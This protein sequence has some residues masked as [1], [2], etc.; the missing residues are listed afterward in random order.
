MHIS[1]MDLGLFLLGPIDMF[2]NST[3]LIFTSPDA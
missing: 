2:S 1:L 3:F